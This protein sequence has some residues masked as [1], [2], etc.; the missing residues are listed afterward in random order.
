MS[1]LAAAA[2]VATSGFVFPWF[3]A[4]GDSRTIEWKLTG[5]S[6]ITENGEQT[7][8]WYPPILAVAVA[9]AFFAGRYLTKRGDRRPA[10][11]ASL[12]VAISGATLLTVI[13]ASF[14]ARTML[15]AGPDARFSADMTTSMAPAAFITAAVGLTLLVVGAVEHRRAVT[16]LGSRDPFRRPPAR[17]VEVALYLLLLT[18]SVAV[19]AALPTAVHSI[20]GSSVAESDGLT[21][22]VVGTGT[23]PDGTAS[24]MF[25][26]WSATPVLLVMLMLIGAISCVHDKKLQGALAGLRPTGSV[27]WGVS[28]LLLILT[29]VVGFLAA[30]L[31][32]LDPT[33]VGVDFTTKPGLAVWA[34][35]AIGAVMFGIAVATRLPRLQLALTARPTTDLEPG[36]PFSPE[37]VD[38]AHR[39][40]TCATALIDESVYA[41]RGTEVSGRFLP[42]VD[43][44]AVVWAVE[45]LAERD[46]AIADSIDRYG[47]EAVVDAIATLASGHDAERLRLR[48][49]MSEQ[50]L[51]ELASVA[52]T[53]MFRIFELSGVGRP[54]H[55]P[56][57][58]G[59]AAI[60][61]SK[62]SGIQSDELP[63]I[64]R[65]SAIPD[66]DDLIVAY[67]LTDRTPDN[68]VRFTSVAVRVSADTKMTTRMFRSIAGS[69][70]IRYA[71]AGFGSLT[72]SEW[73]TRP[74][75]RAGAAPTTE[76]ELK[77]R[78]VDFWR[79][80]ALEPVDDDAAELPTRDDQPV[81]L[82]V[83]PE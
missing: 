24:T 12:Q 72:W 66:G 38:A 78:L 11:S 7:S 75:F 30:T 19:I 56:D 21:G 15:V 40:N 36:R 47:T 54:T 14:A 31:W 42:V 33:D 17:R 74:E 4:R 26:G 8:S 69:A 5:T 79:H 49:S 65:V 16:A 23:L 13:A 73:S 51:E 28:G 41:Y 25:D 61:M 67:L 68:G 63:P 55:T 29:A 62:D 20:D 77:S 46:P 10:E 52:P 50:F 48:W 59:D 37:L 71:A 35:G 6:V 70:A 9:I 57:E 76:F 32:A 3:T 82:P 58:V 83:E 45:D 39:I 34:T 81:V 22:S 27:P 18:A 2:V 44:A 53:T 80:V 64:E 43:V 1:R 60:I